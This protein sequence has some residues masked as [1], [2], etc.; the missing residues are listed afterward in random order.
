MNEVIVT[1]KHICKAFPGVKALDDVNFELKAGEVMALLGENG[2]GKTTLADII[3]GILTP[4]QGGVYV[5]GENIAGHPGSWHSLL[6]YI[7][8]TIFLLDDTGLV[9]VGLDVRHLFQVADERYVDR[10]GADTLFLVGDVV[11]EIM[12]FNVAR[13]SNHLF[14]NLFPES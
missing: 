3:L 10:I 4:E 14:P 1:M 7:P 8:Q 5:D 12:N 6:G 11:V 13:K 2:A 9:N